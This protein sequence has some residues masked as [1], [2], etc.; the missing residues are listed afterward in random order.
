MCLGE[1]SRPAYE[2]DRKLKTALRKQLQPK[3]KDLPVQVKG[4]QA[5]ASGAEAEQ[6]AVL[7]DYA[8]GVLTA[9][10]RD[11]TLPFEYPAV[12]AGEDLDAVETSLQDRAKKGRV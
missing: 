6:L 7:D 11:G 5:E 10:N 1:A 9:L 12:Q 3:I 8:L 4:R 2:R